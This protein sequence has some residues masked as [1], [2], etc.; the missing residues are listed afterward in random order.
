[1]VAMVATRLHWQYRTAAT[2]ATADSLRQTASLI[3]SNP[4]LSALAKSIIAE[5]MT[6]TASLLEGTAGCQ[7]PQCGPT[8]PG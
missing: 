5:K 8:G 4:S 2:K 7:P 3:T 1:M 6:G